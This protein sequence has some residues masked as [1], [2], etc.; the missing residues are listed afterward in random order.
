MA[1][2]ASLSRQEWEIPDSGSTH[3]DPLLGCLLAL[4]RIEQRP[5]SADALIAGLPLVDNRLNPELFVRAAK[6][7]GLAARVIKRP[8][9]EI[10]N[11]VLPAVLLLRGEQACILE[12][13]TDEATARLILPDAG[14][15][16]KEMPLAELADEYCGYAIFV[17]SNYQFDD[18]TRTTATAQTAHWFWSTFRESWPIYSE[19]IIASL[20]INLFALASPLFIMNVYDR[21]VP[22]HAVETLWVLAIGVAIVYGFDLLMRTLRG[23]FVDI[24]GKRADIILSATVF[25]RVL[26]I[27]M[28]ARPPSVGAFANKAA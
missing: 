21:V 18:R 1:Q 5:H 12:A 13:I 20:L 7:A 23:Y 26:G 2:Q 15:G 25:E 6:R 10:S 11:L 14:D 8:L 4:T 28:S 9:D 27:K 3:D 17:Q 16:I 19:V 22:N 24:A